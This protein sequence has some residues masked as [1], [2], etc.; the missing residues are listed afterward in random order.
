MRYFAILLLE[1]F[2]VQRSRCAWSRDDMERTWRRA[3]NEMCVTSEEH[4]VLLTE[5]PLNTA[6]NREH[7]TQVPAYSDVEANSTNSMPYII[8]HWFPFQYDQIVR[9]WNLCL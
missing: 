5:S 4:P 9:T 3:Y 1:A 7:A 8:A 2:D 6:K